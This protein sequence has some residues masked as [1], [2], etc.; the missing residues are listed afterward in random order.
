MDYAQ[1]IKYPE[2]MRLAAARGIKVNAVQAGAARDT[3]RVWR[4]IAQMGHGEYIPIPQ[5]G[6][7]VA[8]IET[9]YDREI[10]ELQGRINHTVVPYGSQTQ[11]RMIRERVEL[12]AAA[13]P[14]VATDAAAYMAKRAA[15]PGSGRAADA[16]TG[17]GDLVGDVAAGRQ[18]LSGLRDNDLPDELR[19]MSPAERQSHLE[20]RMQERRALNERL[21]EVVRQRDRHI[22]DARSQEPR[23][24][25]DSFD[26]AV[27]RTLRAQIAR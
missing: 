24:A 8:V 20:R 3:E 13:P 1:D 10:N 14:S 12:Q 6:G 7:K 9:P 19:R 5:D 27:E 22:A 11:Q 26:R 16:L 18:S 2:V 15:R 25:A 4:A 17:A 23:P 21:A